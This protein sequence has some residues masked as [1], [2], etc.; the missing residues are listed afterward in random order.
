MTDS[1]GGYLCP[2][3]EAELSENILGV[4]LRGVATSAIDISDGLLGD[5]GHILERSNAGAEIEL[6]NIPCDGWLRE[7]INDSSPAFPAREFV[8]AGG[9]DYELCF[10]APVASDDR[11]R[12]AGRQSGVAVTPI[13]RIRAG[14]GVQVLD[15]NGAPLDLTRIRGFDHFAVAG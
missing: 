13:G 9:D 3:A 11:V 2:R 6:S 14:T 7:Q 5:L 8:L 15:G 4:A 12:A 1:P 10:T